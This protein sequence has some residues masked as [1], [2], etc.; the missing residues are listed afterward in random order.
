MC[1][2]PPP[3]LFLIFLTLCGLW[4]VNPYPSSILSFRSSVSLWFIPP[5][6]AVGVKHVLNNDFKT[7]Q[8]QAGLSELSL[9]Q[10]TTKS[11]EPPNRAHT[12]ITLEHSVWLE[13]CPVCCQA[14]HRNEHCARKPYVLN[15]RVFVSA[16]FRLRYK[17]GTATPPKG[18]QTMTLSNKATKEACKKCAKL[19]L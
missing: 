17:A 4:L 1:H 10:P 16:D 11:H 14:H 7:P 2:L 3:F 8:R 9:Q 15:S 5:F 6:C 18:C 19:S 12:E 13:T